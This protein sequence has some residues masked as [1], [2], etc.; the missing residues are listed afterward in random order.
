LKSSAQRTFFGGSFAPLERAVPGQTN[1][2]GKLRLV[3][4][5]FQATDRIRAPQS[6]RETKNACS[7]FLD[8]RNARTT[9]GKHD[10]FADL[11]EKADFVEFLSDDIECLFEAHAHDASKVLKA[12]GSFLHPK[13]VREGET[14]TF[15]AIVHDRRTVIDFELLGAAERDLE[16]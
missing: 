16:A 6:N 2:R 8:I 9:A 3:E 5:G 10:P 15:G 11:V 7:Q 13:V 1:A 4:R 12:D 14:L